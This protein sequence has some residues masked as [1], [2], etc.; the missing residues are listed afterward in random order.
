[1]RPI[2][3]FKLQFRSFK[4]VGD[5]VSYSIQVTD[6][7]V[8]LIFQGS[9]EK[10]DWINNF[11]FF[12][13]P[14][15]KMPTLWYCH[16][17][18]LRAWKSCKDIITKEVIGIL[19]DNQGK[20]LV[21]TG[22][23]HGA[24]LATLAHEW[25]VFNDYYPRTYVFGCPRVFYLPIR[26]IRRRFG[27]LS[28]YGTKGDIVTHVPPALFGYRHVNKVFR[29]GKKNILS[30]KPHYPECYISALEEV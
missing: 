3:F 4:N 16:A 30:H 11:H 23:S 20:R 1:M 12:V 21:I 19:N 10:R 29:I 13:K 2:D 8:I 26:K 24:A 22:Y 6:H 7:D 27:A 28:S 25:F 17:G 18:F 9:Y 5:D 15:K 14:Y